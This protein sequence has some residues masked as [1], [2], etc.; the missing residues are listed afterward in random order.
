MQIKYSTRIVLIFKT[1]VIKIPICK[2][3]YLQGKNEN[4]IWLRYNKIAPLSFLKW[5]YF[6][7][8][9][10]QRYNLVSMI[11]DEEVLK[12]KKLIPSFDF[13]N[14]D[15][16]NHNNWGISEDKYYLLDYGVNERIS[17]MYH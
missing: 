16:Y 14:C 4:Q 12:M 9:C 6:G 8:V 3:G 1:F 5:E 11:P 17:Q 10:Q 2:R 7:V 15:L 13:D